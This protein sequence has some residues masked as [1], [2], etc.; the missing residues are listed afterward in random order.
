MDSSKIQIRSANESR[1]E[2]I[3]TIIA[4]EHAGNRRINFIKTKSLA[5]LKLNDTFAAIIVSWPEKY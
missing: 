5:L 1:L 4:V 2:D 3:V